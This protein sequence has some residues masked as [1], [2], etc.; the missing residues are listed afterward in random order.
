MGFL[1]S[2]NTLEWQ[3]AKK[4]AEFIRSEGIK[5]FLVRLAASLSVPTVM[6]SSLTPFANF[7]FALL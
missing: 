7:C 3:E 2:G 1:S 4:Y 6:C 5:Q